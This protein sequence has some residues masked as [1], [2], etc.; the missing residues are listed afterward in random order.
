MTRIGPLMNEGRTDFVKSRQG[1]ARSREFG[2][3]YEPAFDEIECGCG[4]WFVPV[5]PGQSDC[6]QCRKERRGAA[7]AQGA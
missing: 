2:R 6:H 7:Q 1:R 5:R 3:L 4:G